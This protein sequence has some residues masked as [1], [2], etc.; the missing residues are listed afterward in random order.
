MSSLFLKVGVLFILVFNT[1]TAIEF[2]FNTPGVNAVVTSMQVRHE[3]LAKYYNSGAV[4]LNLDGTI[5]LRDE[6]SV[7]LAYR[8]TLSALVD[9]ENE[10][11]DKLYAEISN[12]N[13]HPEWRVEVHAVFAK[14]WLMHAHHGWWVMSD[15]GWIQ[16]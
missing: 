15:H 9:A 11:R 14:R 3:K 12:A 7:P 13:A 4:G 16:K 5:S 2:E 6:A 1:C 10:D 8:R